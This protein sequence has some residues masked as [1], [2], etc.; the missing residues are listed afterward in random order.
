MTTSTSWR[1]RPMTTSISSPYRVSWQ[2]PS[3]SYRGAYINLDRHPERRSEIDKQLNAL[4]I[5]DRYIRFPAVDGASIKA[6]PKGISAAAAGCF[7][8]HYL[9]LE[10]FKSANTC[11]HVLEDDAILTS[12][13]PQIIDNGQRERQ[14]D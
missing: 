2:P 13:L 10:K 8:S 9:A 11:V 5:A 1:L 6:L 14:F 12:Y 3:R 4:G 7:W